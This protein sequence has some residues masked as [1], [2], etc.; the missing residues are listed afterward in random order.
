MS[1]VVAMICDK[2]EIVKEFRFL[3]DMRGKYNSLKTVL[4]RL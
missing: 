4:V 2:I 3:N 1:Y